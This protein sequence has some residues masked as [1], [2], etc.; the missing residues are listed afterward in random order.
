MGHSRPTCPAP[1]PINAASTPKSGQKQVRLVCPLSA[2]YRHRCRRPKP[3]R[4]LRAVFIGATPARHPTVFVFGRSGSQMTRHSIKSLTPMM[5]RECRPTRR[6]LYTGRLETS[7]P[8]SLDEDVL[9]AP[10]DHGNGQCPLMG[11]TG[12]LPQPRSNLQGLLPAE[13]EKQRPAPAKVVQ[14]EY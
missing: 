13:S 6:S 4:R 9:V 12:C 5:L 8:P 10:D 1:V 3:T 7:R 11:W 14:A 2:N